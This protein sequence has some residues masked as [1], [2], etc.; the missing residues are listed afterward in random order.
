HHGR[1]GGTGLQPHGSGAPGLAGGGGEPA[2]HGGGGDPR[3]IQARQPG[4]ARRVSSACAVEALA[5]TH[6]DRM[7]AADAI[8]ERLASRDQDETVWRS[9]EPLRRIADAFREQV[10]AEA[11]VAEAVKAARQAGF[12]WNAI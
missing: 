3:G 6:R 2:R 5:R 9:S 7:A 4:V 1:P 10:A 8:A 11:K 12:S